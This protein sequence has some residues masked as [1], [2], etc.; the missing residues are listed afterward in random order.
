[1]KRLPDELN[2]ATRP[3]YD[4]PVTPTLLAWYRRGDALEP[5]NRAWAEKLKQLEAEGEGD[6]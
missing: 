4:A 5:N 3:V 6:E 2:D 1:M